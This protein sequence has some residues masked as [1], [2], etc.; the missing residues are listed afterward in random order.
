MCVCVGGE[1]ATALSC[2]HLPATAVQPCE[3]RSHSSRACPRSR[4]LCT[5]ARHPAKPC[6]TRRSPAPAAGEGNLPATRA[7]KP[8][9]MVATTFR[10]GTRRMQPLCGEIRYF[11]APA[12]HSMF[13]NCLTPS[14]ATLDRDHS[15][16]CSV[17]TEGATASV[18]PMHV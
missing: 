15:K 5:H 11:M 18:T 2:V 3:R 14:K 12:M 8:C 13:A 4:R 9:I 17:V 1:L 16:D 7:S 6:S 10:E